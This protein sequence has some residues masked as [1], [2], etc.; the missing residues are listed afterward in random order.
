M[1]WTA[2][3]SYRVNRTCQYRR[4]PGE[5]LGGQDTLRGPGVARS[6]RELRAGDADGDGGDADGRPATSLVCVSAIDYADGVR[7]PDDAPQEEEQGENA[8]PPLL[9]SALA[10]VVALAAGVVV[11]L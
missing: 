4:T 6:A 5:C 10:L 7:R 8:A 9:T 3:D 11:A 1:T 2:E